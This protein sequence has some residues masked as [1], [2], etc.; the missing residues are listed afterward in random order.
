LA[1]GR[2]DLTQQAPVSTEDEL[3]A[4]ARAFNFMLKRLRQLI[5]QQQ[6]FVANASHEL[7]TPMTNIKLRSEAL[8]NGGKDD[9]TIMVRYLTEIDSEADR[10]RRLATTLLDLA[11]LEANRPDQKAP[12]Q[13]MD[14]TASVQT[15]ISTMQWRAQQAGLTFTAQNA[16]SMPPLHVWPEHLEEILVNLIDNAIKFTPSGGAIQLTI[17]I[18]NGNCRFQVCDSGPGIPA[19]EIPYIFD[20]FY[21]VD[22]ARSRRRSQTSVGSGAGLGLAIVKTLVEINNGKVWAENLATPGASFVVEFPLLYSDV[23]ITGIPPITQ[24]KKT[25]NL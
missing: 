11:Q 10:L 5:E 13:P 19:E 3:G 21:R 24:I 9:P 15:V 12:D 8:L 23:K 2:G 22:K 1:V 6:L 25:K 14:L 16:D 17:T 18:V 7:R 20:R 4:L